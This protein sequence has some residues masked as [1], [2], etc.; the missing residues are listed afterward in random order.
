MLAAPR[1]S[2]TACGGA[3]PS[4]WGGTSSVAVPRSALVPTDDK[5]RA[6]FG[7]KGTGESTEA[8]DS[9]GGGGAMSEVQSAN[10][11]HLQR[12]AVA[13]LCSRDRGRIDIVDGCSANRQPKRGD[14]Y[15]VGA[16]ASACEIGG[17]ARGTCCD[18]HDADQRPR[19]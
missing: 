10:L 16:T 13:V 1:R 5:G 8:R 15:R 3:N 14:G 18:D 6:D 9:G 12:S 4:Q 7:R 19:A 17:E 11:S 2:R